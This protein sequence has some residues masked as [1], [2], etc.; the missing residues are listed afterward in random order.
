MVDAFLLDEFWKISPKSFT[1]STNNLS[2]TWSRL[3]HFYVNFSIQVQGVNIEFG[4]QWV[5]F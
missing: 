2:T 4:P 1:W 3:D 5:M